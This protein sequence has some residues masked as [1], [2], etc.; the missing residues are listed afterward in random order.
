MVEKLQQKPIP[1]AKEPSPEV[2]SKI[3]D[4]YLFDN[5][6]EYLDKEVEEERDGRWSAAAKEFRGYSAKITELGNALK[7][8]ARKKE[9][10][11]KTA[12]STKIFFIHVGDKEEAIDFLG[13]VCYSRIKSSANFGEIIRTG[14]NESKKMLNEI[15]I[16]TTICGRVVN[17]VTLPE[18]I[19]SVLQGKLQLKPSSSQTKT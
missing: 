11:P 7:D 12:K 8:V 13:D 2:I 1:E 3:V 17:K 16:E 6:T 14:S 19:S 15:G 9:E 5:K 4:L 10:F 18:A